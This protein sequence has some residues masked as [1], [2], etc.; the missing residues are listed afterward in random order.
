MKPFSAWRADILSYYLTTFAIGIAGMVIYFS[1]GH[2]S[3]WVGSALI[4]AYMLLAVLSHAGA[5]RWDTRWTWALFLIQTGL[6]TALLW[7]TPEMSFFVIWYY[8]LGVTAV[9]VFPGRIA[10]GWLGLFAL[11]TVALL[12]RAYG[13]LD[14][15]PSIAIYLSG[16]GFFLA[17]ARTTR[18]AQ[19]SRLESERLLAELQE[20][21]RTLQAYAAKIEALAVAEERNHLAR[22]MHDTLGHRLT[23]A[24]VQLEAAERLIPDQP[25]RAAG[26]VSTVRQQVRAALAELRRTVA[27]L[28][29]PLED[30]LLLEHALPR[31]VDDF[32]QATGLEI[33]L[34]LPETWPPLSP[35]QRLTLFRAAQEGLTNAY[36][37]AAARHIWLTLENANGQMR[38][39][40]RDDGRGPQSTDGGFGLR[41]LRER[42]VHLGG[43]MHFGPAPQGGAQLKITL[44]LA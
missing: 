15:M 22:E 40:V 35:A 27:T 41:G 2:P 32:R 34:A 20:A 4:L 6:V 25:E 18:Q 10:T 29:Q 43:E 38:L 1:N 23:V 28:R 44:P 17:F 36:K 8:V 14:A 42:A 16:F 30:D 26:M 33:T 31:L 12:W 11:L 9:I 21:H 5:G 19:E 3:R 13:L 39:C 7:L 24:A 37:H